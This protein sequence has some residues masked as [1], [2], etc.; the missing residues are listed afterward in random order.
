MESKWTNQSGL[1]M[2]NAAQSFLFIDP[3]LRGSSAKITHQSEHD[4]HYGQPA[5]DNVLVDD[6]KLK[7]SE[8]VVGFLT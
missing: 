4:G 3:L 6:R 7:E 8:E 1:G 5:G 2:P